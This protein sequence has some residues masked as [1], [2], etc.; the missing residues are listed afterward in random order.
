MLLNGEQHS[1]TPKHEAM[2][3]TLAGCLVVTVE[4][5]Q[6]FAHTI[7]SGFGKILMG[8]ETK[9]KTTRKWSFVNLTKQS[10]LN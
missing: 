10:I 5:H 4:A 9:N 2:L 1:V 3:P 6:N 8:N 7:L